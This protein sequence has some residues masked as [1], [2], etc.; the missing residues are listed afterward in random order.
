MQIII[1]GIEYD[2]IPKASK[3]HKQ[4]RIEVKS[5]LN[6]N[7]DADNV[8]YELRLNKMIPPYMGKKA[9]EAIESVLNND[10]VVE[11]DLSG[12]EKHF[13][14]KRYTQSEVDTIRRETWEQC[15][16]FID[17]HYFYHEGFKYPTLSDY[18]SSLNSKD[19]GKEY[20]ESW[21]GQQEKVKEEKMKELFKK[22]YAEPSALPTKEWEIVQYR[23]KTNGEI[24][25]LASVWNN[26]YYKNG[27]KDRTG[28]FGEQQDVFDIYSV[29]RLSDNVVF[30]VGDS[31]CLNWYPP[32]DVVQPIKRIEIENGN[33]YLY[34]DKTSKYELQFARIN[35]KHKNQ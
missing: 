8:M 13:T 14:E 7:A 30:S 18:L 10:T 16:K 26:P 12:V 1:E 21:A 29:I 15:R 5:I 9:A 17:G 34:Y 3:Q 11:D 31:V 6:I 4:G 2:L 33:I 35:P 24:F 20:K 19:T 25:E 28:G 23:N 32:F 22:E 27:F